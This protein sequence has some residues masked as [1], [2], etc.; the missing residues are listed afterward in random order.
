[1]FGCDDCFDIIFDFD[2]ACNGSG[3]W[4]MAGVDG[5]VSFANGEGR[6]VRGPFKG[7]VEAAGVPVFVIPWPS[8][9]VMVV[10]HIEINVLLFSEGALDLL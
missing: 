10:G 1:M 3:W 9:F 2:P 4:S 5:P 6:F 7:L 8:V